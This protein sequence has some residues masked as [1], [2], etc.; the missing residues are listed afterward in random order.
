MDFRAIHLFGTLKDTEHFYLFGE[1]NVKVKR[2]V[3]WI[4]ETCVLAL[5]WLGTCCVCLVN[6]LNLSVLLCS[7]VIST[8]ECCRDENEVR[9]SKAKHLD[10]IICH[11]IINNNTSTR[12]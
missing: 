6:A 4:K 12:D 1:E 11:D 7:S 5:V 9:L 10:N 3:D 8:Q 2:T